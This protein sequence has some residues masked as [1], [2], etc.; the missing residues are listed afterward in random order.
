MHEKAAGDN[1]LSFAQNFPH[2]GRKP[3]I[4]AD[5]NLLV[6]VYSFLFRYPTAV[7]A[8]FYN[9]KYEFGK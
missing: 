3:Q 2:C 6:Q 4:P 8:E 9:A 5:K 1:R 7:G